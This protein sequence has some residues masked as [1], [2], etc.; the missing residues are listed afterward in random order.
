MTTSA[1]M[2]TPHTVLA[3]APATDR[4]AADWPALQAAQAHDPA[5]RVAFFIE[6]AGR[7][8]HSDSVA[9]QHLPALARWAWALQIDTQGVMLRLITAWRDEIYPVLGLRDGRR[10]Q[11]LMGIRRQ[12][13]VAQRKVQRGQAG[14]DR[15]LAR[16]GMRQGLGDRHQLQAV[17][18][19]VLVARHQATRQR[20]EAHADHFGLKTSGMSRAT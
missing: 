20:Q 18:L 8:W 2:P 15:H 5:A 14:I 10:L 7:T 19:A 12:Q 4:P 3:P 16:S 17:Q 1:A 6:D 13:P 9:R 11:V